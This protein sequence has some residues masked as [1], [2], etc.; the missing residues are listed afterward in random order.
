M[1]FSVKDRKIQVMPLATQCQKHRKYCI[2]TY[3]ANCPLPYPTYADE[4]SLLVFAPFLT[5]ASLPKNKFFDRLEI[6][7]TERP[8]VFLV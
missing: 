5:S 3:F 2:L 7:V 1:C 8:R 6:P 4:G